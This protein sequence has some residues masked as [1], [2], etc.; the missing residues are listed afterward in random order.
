MFGNHDV[1]VVDEAPD[2]EV[3]SA[4]EIVLDR[5]T[6]A[7]S[8]IELKAEIETLK[9]LEALAIEVR[10]SGADRRELASLL[11]GIFEVKET[12]GKIAEPDVP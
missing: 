6:P 11:G 4:E 9:H 2:D 1:E 5:A 8:I 7:R 10:R 3:A 12:S